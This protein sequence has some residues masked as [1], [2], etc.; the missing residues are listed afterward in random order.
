MPN[1]YFSSISVTKH[2]E[3]AIF[4]D[5]YTWKILEILRE[6]G[7]KGLTADDIYRKL[8]QKMG[9]SVSKSKVYGLLKRLYMEEWIGRYYDKDAG[10][11]RVTSLFHWGVMTAHDR[12]LVEEKFE[13][14]VKSKE[15]DYIRGRLFPVMLEY[16]KNTLHDLGDDP[17]TKKFKP[18]IGDY[19]IECHGSHEAIEFFTCLLYIALDRFLDEESKVF[20]EFMIEN[21][22]A[23]QLSE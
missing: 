15:M 1:A 14:A 20:D 16:I 23:R 19:C 11:Q 12:P 7:A 17:K 10:A 6:T 13:D 9:V 3:A 22:F 21:K 4:S 18:E 5:P 2:Q 8:Q